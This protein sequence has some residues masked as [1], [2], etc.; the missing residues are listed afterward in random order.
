LG[1]IVGVDYG[2]KRVGLA[3]S[4]PSGSFALPWTTA[5]HGVNEVARLIS[6]RKG[7]IS[8]IVVGLPLHLN[9]TESPLSRQAR[10]FA[11]ALHQLTG[12]PV[13]LW[14]ERLSSKQA[15]KSLTGMTRKQK[16]GRVDQ[17]AATII[18]ESYLASRHV[19]P[20]SSENLSQ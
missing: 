20:P 17:A 12:I 13:H 3:I 8:E 4:D 18:L 15:E 14:D 7:E 11:A 9:G 6:E 10:D 5:T 2:L 16:S 19:P 1:R